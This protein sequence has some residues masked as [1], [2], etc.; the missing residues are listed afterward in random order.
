VAWSDALSSCLPARLQLPSF[1]V[2]PP[3]QAA[4]F[5]AAAYVQL[6]ASQSRG[7]AW[8]R[9]LLGIP[10]REVHVCGDHSCISIVE[11]VCAAAGMALAVNKFERLTSLEIDKHGLKHGSYANVQRGD[12]VIAFARKD[13][14]AI[15]AEIDERSS[16]RAAL[17]Y[18]GLPPL[19]RRAQASVFNASSSECQVSPFLEPESELRTGLQ[20]LSPCCENAGTWLQAISCRVCVRLT[21]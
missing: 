19:A 8:T 15:K 11:S 5:I 20:A 12:C 7:W 6:I 21:I 9:A 10:A 3:E 14:Y 17:V 13:L 16:H 2:L 4:T 18:G 1:I